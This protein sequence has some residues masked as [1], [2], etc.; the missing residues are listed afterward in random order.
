MINNII[1]KIKFDKHLFIFTLCFG[2][3][4]YGGNN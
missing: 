1:S 4:T 2:I 3:G